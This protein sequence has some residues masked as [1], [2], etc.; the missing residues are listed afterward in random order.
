MNHVL[1][2]N[3]GPRIVNIVSLKV[4]LF[5]E[6]LCIHLQ[7]LPSQLICFFLSVIRSVCCNF[8]HVAKEP[9]ILSGSATGFEILREI[10]YREAYKFWRTFLL[11]LFVCFLFCFS[12]P[13]K[14]KYCSNCKIT[15]LYARIYSRLGAVIFPFCSALMRP[16]LEYCVQFWALQ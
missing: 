7:I 13:G 10:I 3:K 14:K 16:H 5:T 6:F 1:L 2:W 12:V 4:S 8:T 9:P 15:V 11:V